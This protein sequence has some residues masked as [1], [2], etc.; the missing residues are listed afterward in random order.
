MKSIYPKLSQ[1]IGIIRTQLPGLQKLKAET[2]ERVRRER[3][4]TGQT[5]KGER[6]RAWSVWGDAA[7]RCYRHGG[8]ET[9]LI[10]R[11]ERHPACACRAYSFPHRAGSGF[12]NY[13]DEPLKEHPTP[14]GQRRYYKRIRKKRIKNWMENLGISD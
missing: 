14:Q 7:N 1:L 10:P 4:C 3:Q 12:C 6:C 9:A 5:S 8:A 2:R 13:P 11:S